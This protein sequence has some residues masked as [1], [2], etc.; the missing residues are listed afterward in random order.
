VAALEDP[1]FMRRDRPRPLLYGDGR[2]AER[3]VAAVE[4]YAGSHERAQAREAA[5]T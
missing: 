4:R 2:A 5:T 3:I 1:E